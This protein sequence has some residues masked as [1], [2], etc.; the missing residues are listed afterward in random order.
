MRRLFLCTGNYYRSRFAEELFNHFAR[1]RG[2]TWRADSAGLARDF[3]AFR[4][5]GPMSVLAVA[6]LKRLGVSPLRTGDY[7][8]S[9]SEADFAGFA[10]VVA[11]SEAEHRPMMQAYFPAWERVIQ[12][13]EVGDTPVEAAEQALAKIA[14]L[15]AQLA[16]EL[17]ARG[18]AEPR[19]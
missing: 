12:Y 13:W 6:E 8:R 17:A 3:S 11:L 5:P 9:A 7:P 4:N 1:E 15:T 14:Q 16:G 10:P 2:L 19:V 18:T